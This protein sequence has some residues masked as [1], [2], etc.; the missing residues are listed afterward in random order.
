MLPAGAQG[1]ML[2][3][4]PVQTMNSIHRPP[5]PPTESFHRRDKSDGDIS[6][7]A[8]FTNLAG[9]PELQQDGLKRTFSD[10]FLNLAPQ[11]SENERLPYVQN[12]ELFRRLSRGAQGKIA[13]TGFTLSAEELGKLAR[14]ETNPNNDLTFTEK[15]R[16]TSTR[17]VSSRIRTLARRSFRQSSRSLSPS[18]NDLRT[19]TNGQVT[20]SKPSIGT[21]AITKSA[22]PLPMRGRAE[23]EQEQKPGHTR[24][25][26]LSRRLSRPLSVIVSPNKSDS[27]RLS[28]RQS[29]SLQSLR[30]NRSTE[31]F[32]PMPFH[33]PPVPSS[34]STE[35]LSSMVYDHQKKKDP[36]W[37]VFRA[38]EGDFQKWV[39]PFRT[40]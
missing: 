33:V 38:L 20:P 14:T 39:T 30:S 37:S 18:P 31:K 26:S 21:T 6:R 35:R 16:P 32:P 19:R 22:E 34:L 3:A 4:V 8:S 13:V 15:A 25:P 9:G 12:K 29:P 1:G 40:L 10:N 23:Q 7:S 24:R 17:S 36:L 5:S 28:L 27:D 11:N 2:S